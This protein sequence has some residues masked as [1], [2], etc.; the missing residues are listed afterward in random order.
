MGGGFSF[1]FKLPSGGTDKVSGRVVGMS[2]KN[3]VELEVVGHS[4]IPDGIY[5]L[6][7]SKGETVKAILSLDAVE[8]LPENKAIVDSSL[9]VDIGEPMSQPSGW[10]P[11]EVPEGA[12]KEWESPEG[13]ISRQYADGYVLYEKDSSGGTG[14]EIARGDSWADIL[15]KADSYGEKIGDKENDAGTNTTEPS[16]TEAPG[17]Q[18]P[19]APRVVNGVTQ[20]ETRLPQGIEPVDDFSEAIEKGLPWSP[21]LAQNYPPEIQRAIDRIYEITDRKKLPFVNTTAEAA[22]PEK[23]AYAK[24]DM[25]DIGNQIYQHFASMGVP[26]EGAENSTGWS[27]DGAFGSSILEADDLGKA[28]SPAFIMTTA[29]IDRAISDVQAHEAIESGRVS[30]ESIMQLSADFNHDRVMTVVPLS[31]VDS[32]LASRRIMS[33][34]EVGESRGY[35]APGYR[36]LAEANQYGY[37][38]NM[39]PSSRPIYGVSVPERMNATDFRWSEMYGELKFVLKNDVQSRT[40]YTLGDSLNSAARPAPIGVVAPTSLYDSGPVHAEAQMHGGV[41]L[42]DVSEVIV[43]EDSMSP[44]VLNDLRA[45]IEAAGIKFT[46]IQLTNYDNDSFIELKVDGATVDI[47]VPTRTSVV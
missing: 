46:V 14:N 17:A 25:I 7:A 36:S 39:R 47:V 29:L 26:T 3:D 35:L 28:H 32:I 2:G 16:A 30:L 6:P 19:R 42:D 12:P 15:P 9:A 45:K 40:T 22:D 38:P 20:R 33:Q 1:S 31:A 10:T 23:R 43:R 34:F 8:G 27:Y 21:L 37:P 13:L 44:D 11:L 18:E 41:S 4:S 5:A 24:E